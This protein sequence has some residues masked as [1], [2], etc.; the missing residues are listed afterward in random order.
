MINIKHLTKQFGKDILLDDISLIIHE[1][2]KIALVG[3][4]GTGKSTLV[5]CISGL[6]DYEGEI[7]TEDL[8]ICLMEQERYFEGLDETFDKYLKKKEKEVKD[9]QDSVKAKLEDPKTYESEERNLDG[10]SYGDR[11][12]SGEGDGDGSGRE[13]WK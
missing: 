3:Q 4:N 7:D 10:N 12:E 13:R 6:E 2:N 11:D 5:R 1:G 8:K 9:F